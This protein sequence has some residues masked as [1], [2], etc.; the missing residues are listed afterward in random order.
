MAMYSVKLFFG[1]YVNEELADELI[2]VNPKLLALF[3]Q[4][5]E[6]YLKEIEI[7]NKRYIGKGIESSI[8]LVSLELLQANIYSLLKKILPTYPFEKSPLILLPS[9]DAQ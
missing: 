4:N 8:D 2:K 5:E 6:N 1:F 7:Q 9:Q 3:I